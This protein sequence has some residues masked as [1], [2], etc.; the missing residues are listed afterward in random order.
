MAKKMKITALVSAL[1]TVLFAVLYKYTYTTLF[2]PLA[3]TFGT[4]AYHLIMRLVVGAVING[5]FH[6]RINY[7]LR[8]FRVGNTEQR[9][10]KVI[11][12]HKW[13]AKM[14][15]YDPTI[16]D[17][18]YHTWD[19]IAQA[20]CQA[21]L[22]HEAIIVLSFLPII[23]AVYFGSLSVFI[24]T[25]VLSACYDGIFVIMQ[26][27]NRPRIIRLIKAQKRKK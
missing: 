6:N 23:S 19:E 14:P 5:I 10:Y 12:V 25:S 11:G 9:L 21:E 26:R 17:P 8:W 27:Y 24:I 7:S 22:V 4:T 13:K 15:T 1:L 3:I 18:K 16:F 2:L 20:T